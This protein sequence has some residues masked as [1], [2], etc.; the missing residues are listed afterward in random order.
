MLVSYV[1][2]EIIRSFEFKVKLLQSFISDYDRACTLNH[3]EDELRQFL[4]YQAL[5]LEF[6]KK[7]S[8]FKT[9]N[10]MQCFCKTVLGRVNSL[11]AISKKDSVLEE[12]RILRDRPL[13]KITDTVKSLRLQLRIQGMAIYGKKSVMIDRIR[14]DAIRLQP[15]RIVKKNIETAPG[16]YGGGV[17]QQVTSNLS[18]DD[19][20]DS[21][22]K[23]NDKYLSDSSLDD[24]LQEGA[25]TFNTGIR[26]L[27]SWFTQFKKRN[28]F[29]EDRRTCVYRENYLEKYSLLGRCRL[30]LIQQKELSVDMAV[31]GLEYI[32]EKQSCSGF[33]NEIDGIMVKD[34][35]KTEKFLKDKK[36]ILP[37]TRSTVHRWMLSLGCEYVKHKSTYYTDRHE[38]SDTVSD[39]NDR[40][41][42]E[43]Y[44]LNVRMQN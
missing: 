10:S 38:Q 1:F 18:D 37:L 22:Y 28:G 11:L 32:I 4:H 21:D 31:K 42:P 44:R 6:N 26:T 13:L 27:R 23:D 43:S 41:I 15:H 35:F 5:I 17:H 8:D 9:E 34:E 7:L 36:Q 16:N 24:A 39:R 12:E 20:M 30:W 25:A 2:Y 19:S 29:F 40:Y 14:G 3:I 33:M